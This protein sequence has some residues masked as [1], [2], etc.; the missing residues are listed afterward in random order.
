MTVKYMVDTRG[1]GE[2]LR[3]LNR[4]HGMQRTRTLVTQSFGPHCLT[5]PRVKE[6]QLVAEVVQST[7]RDA[8]LAGPLLFWPRWRKQ[9]QQPKIPQGWE[10]WL[11]HCEDAQLNPRSKRTTKR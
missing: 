2:P 7:L 6:V 11:S 8:L 5:R 10:Q 1:R 9:S 4:A 3:R